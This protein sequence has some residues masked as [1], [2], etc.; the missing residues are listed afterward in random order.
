MADD[1]D[2]ILQIMYFDKYF[3][4][5]FRYLSS[6]LLGSSLFTVGFISYDRCLHLVRLNQYNMPRWKMIPVLLLCWLVP[7]IIPLFRYSLHHYHF[8]IFHFK[9]SKMFPFF[10]WSDA[11]QSTKTKRVRIIYPI[12]SGKCHSFFVCPSYIIKMLFTIFQIGQ[13]FWLGKY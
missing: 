2:Q 10:K 11:L 13:G 3:C 1:L 7:I 12:H 8:I 6:I 5:L 4:H 9:W